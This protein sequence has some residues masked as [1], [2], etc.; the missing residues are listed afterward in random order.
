M[1]EL[2]SARSRRPPATIIANA[3]KLRVAYIHSSEEATQVADARERALDKAEEH[4]KQALAIHEQLGNR[5][6]RLI[7]ER[8]RAPARI[9]MD[10]ARHR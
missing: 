8:S 9:D 10:C 2:N 4:Y 1:D 6:G 5:L 3:L 7:V